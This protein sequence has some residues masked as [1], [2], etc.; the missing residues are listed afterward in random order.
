MT[1]ADALT[2]MTGLNSTSAF[3]KRENA[4][5]ILYYPELA[6]FYNSTNEAVKAASELSVAISSTG[7]EVY[8]ISYGLNGGT[9]DDSNPNVYS[10]ES[11]DI[12]LEAATRND[13]IF[14]GWYTDEGLTSPVTDVAIPAGT[15]G[16]KTFYAKW[17]QEYAITYNNVNEATNGNP[18]TYT[19]GDDDITLE[20]ATRN[21]YIFGGWYTDAGLTTAVTDVAITAGSTGNK[22]F[23]AKWTAIEYTITYN[24]VN[25][26]TN[27]NQ[28]SYT[29]ESNITLA[30]LGARTGYAFGG[31]YTTEDFSGDKVTSIAAGATGNKTFYAKWTAV[32]GGNMIILIIIIVVVAALL[33][34]AIMMV[35]RDRRKKRATA[36]AA[37]TTTTATTTAATAQTYPQNNQY[38][39]NP[40]GQ[41]QPNP[42]V[43]QQNSYGQYNPYGQQPNPYVQQNPYAQQQQNPYGQSNPYAP[44]NPYSQPQQ[45]Q[46]NP[47]DRNNP[48]NQNGKH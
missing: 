41:Q 25:E 34:V 12:T 3:L 39:Q 15:T 16:A 32:A 17:L 2:T 10:A 9:N 29:I 20:A 47:Y 46:Q 28:V 35:R 31:W 18:V 43:Q 24:N 21:G 30:D 14:G 26:A 11:T 38:G 48:Y 22:T 36:T 23:W 37:A 6:D 4:V 13:Y 8:T 27:S 19:T 45:G 7:G 1:A 5:G 40:Y 44:S 42:Y 33:V